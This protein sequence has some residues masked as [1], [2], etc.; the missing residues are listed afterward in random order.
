MN[1]QENTVYSFPSIQ[2][3]CRNN[4]QKPFIAQHI[5]VRKKAGFPSLFLKLNLTFFQNVRHH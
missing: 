1:I 5:Y 2:K 4:E 3:T